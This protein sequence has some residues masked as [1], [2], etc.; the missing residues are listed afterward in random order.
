[1]RERLRLAV[2]GAVQGVGFRPFVYRLPTNW[3]WTA[4][5]T[6]RRRACSI[7]VEGPAPASRAFAA[8]LRAEKPPRSVIQSLEA[9]WLD[10]AGYA[11][12]RRS[13]ESDARREVA[14]W[15]CPTSRP[16]PTAW[17]EI[18]DPANRRYRYP[19][20][21]CTNCGPRFTIIEALP[22]D[23]A[24]TTMRGFPM[25]AEC[26]REYEDPL[27]P[28]LPCPA[29]RLPDCGPQLALWDARGEVLRRRATRRCWPRREAIR[30]GD[31]RRGQGARRLPPAGRCAQ[32]GGGRAAAAAQAPR[33]EAVRGDVSRPRRRS[34]AAVRCVRR[35]RSGCSTSP[36]SADRAPA[37]QTRAAAMRSRCG[38]AAAIPTSA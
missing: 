28:P 32:R 33:G 11:A 2:R 15:S 3:G 27:R 36:R 37:P 24:D 38:G 12:L 25:C 22:Y 10:P 34:A 35:S 9:S 8:G 21:N 7:E 30:D 13:G 18:F 4:G 31:D 16:A 29:E 1:M 6:T 5:S 19:F 23:R 14:R 17:R 20:T 26:R